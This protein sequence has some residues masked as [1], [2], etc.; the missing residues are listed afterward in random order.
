MSQLIRSINGENIPQNGIGRGSNSS[1]LQSKET[2]KEYLY[3]KDET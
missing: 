1:R 3:K 2:R